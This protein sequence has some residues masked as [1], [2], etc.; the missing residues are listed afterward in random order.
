MEIIL[1]SKVSNWNTV[2][3]KFHLPRI[4]FNKTTNWFDMSKTQT[5]ISFPTKILIEYTSYTNI[6][7]YDTVGEVLIIK[8]VFLGFGFSLYL[9]REVYEY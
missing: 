6:K 2:T 8:L 5:T 3:A 4:N 7:E 1:Y 9:R